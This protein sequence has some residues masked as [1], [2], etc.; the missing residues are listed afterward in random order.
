MKLSPEQKSHI[1]KKLLNYGFYEFQIPTLL[2]GKKLNTNFGH[3][4]IKKPEELHVYTQYNDSTT[5]YNL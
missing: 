5:I 2:Q 3:A 1:T 4:Q